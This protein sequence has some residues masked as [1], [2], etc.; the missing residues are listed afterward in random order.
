MAWLPSHP[1]S[2]LERP[3]AELFAVPIALQLQR[4]HERRCAGELIEGQQPEGVAHEHTDTRGADSGMAKS[5]QHEGESGKAEVRLGLASTCREEEQV[6]DFTV[7]VRGLGD[8]TEVHKQERQLERSPLG[9]VDRVGC[10]AAENRLTPPTGCGHG[11]VRDT[12]RIE[13]VRLFEERY[14]R[15]NAIGCQ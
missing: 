2:D 15:L 11:T 1:Q 4:T 8:P 9:R 6:D 14:A 5:S 13:D 7:R 3:V 12:E 10:N